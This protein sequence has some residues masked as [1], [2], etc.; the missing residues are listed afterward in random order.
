MWRATDQICVSGS[1]KCLDRGGLRA[2]KIIAAFLIALSLAGGADAAKHKKKSKKKSRAKAVVEK[3]DPIAWEA[4]TRDGPGGR[5][6]FAAS[7]PAMTF[8]AGYAHGAVFFMVTDWKGGP[9]DQPSLSVGYPLNP[10]IAPVATVESSAGKAP[11]QRFYVDG[12][13]AFLERADQE[14]NLL[15]SMR[16]GKKMRVEAV[17]ADNMRTTYEFSLSGYSAAAEAADRACL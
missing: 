1:E 10:Q 9:R 4:Q 12:K 5:I 11:Q 3:P 2:L 15:A 14:R 17:S 16:T 13:E 7:E 8:P 6:C